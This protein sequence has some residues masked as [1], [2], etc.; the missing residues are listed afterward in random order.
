[1]L[2]VNYRKM[3][4][5][6]VVFKGE[7]PGIYTSWA[8]CSEQV[9]WYKGAVHKKYSSYEEAVHDFNSTINSIPSSE[10]STSTTINENGVEATPISCCVVLNN[11]A[12]AVAKCFGC[13]HVDE[14]RQ[15]QSLFA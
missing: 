10:P 6:Y 1:M 11:V 13:G 7:N 5:W 9:L 12:R 15:V 14:A 3:C 4:A 8:Q 2:L